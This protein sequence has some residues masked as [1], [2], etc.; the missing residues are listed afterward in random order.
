VDYR[1]PDGRNGLDAIAMVRAACDRDVP[2]I[3]VSG[4]S[5]SEELARIKAAGVM[6][7]H[8]PVSPAKLRAMLGYLLG[9]GG[10]AA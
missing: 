4:E 8:K 1:L 7:L 10:R 3:I 9:H 6:L 5:S 2:A